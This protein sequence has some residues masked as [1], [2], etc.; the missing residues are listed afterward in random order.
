MMNLRNE[1]LIHSFPYDFLQG[2][3]SDSLIIVLSLVETYF[4]KLKLKF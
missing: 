3:T 1:L 4:Y 2:N